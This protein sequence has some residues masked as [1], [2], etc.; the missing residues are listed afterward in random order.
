MTDSILVSVAKAIAE[1][2]E[3]RRKAGDFEVSTFV[4]EWD[5]EGRV[6]DEELTD[7]KLH[8]R[9]IVPRRWE[10]VG[11]AD[12]SSLEYVAAWDIDVRQKLGIAAQDSTQAIEKDVLVKLTRLV[13]QLHEFFWGTLSEARLELT[14]HSMVAEWIDERDGIKKQSEILVAYSTKYL[15]EQRQ[16]YGICREVFEV[17]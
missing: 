9:V 14:D 17:T 4:T 16:F 1:Q 8:V 7:D 2:L 13:E 11:R 5:F 10:H 15:R 3:T 6:A 12:R